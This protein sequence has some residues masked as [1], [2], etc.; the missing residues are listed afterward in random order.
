MTNFIPTAYWH[1]ANPAKIPDSAKRSARRHKGEAIGLE[2]GAKLYFNRKG[3]A[4]VLRGFWIRSYADGATD[5]RPFC[6]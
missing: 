1:K 6:L 2:G 3:Q 5:A 4:S